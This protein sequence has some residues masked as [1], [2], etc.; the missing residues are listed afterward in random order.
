MEGNG[1]GKGPLPKNRPGKSRMD[2]T[3]NQRGGTSGRKRKKRGG[4]KSTIRGERLPTAGSKSGSLMQKRLRKK[5]RPGECMNS[6][7][8][9]GQEIKK[10]KREGRKT[11]LVDPQ[12]ESLKKKKE[13]DWGFEEEPKWGDSTCCKDS[14]KR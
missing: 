6:F 1:K 12:G 13:V 11:I 14:G 10:K 3:R 7:S 4:G 9:T 2:V 5:R 8:I